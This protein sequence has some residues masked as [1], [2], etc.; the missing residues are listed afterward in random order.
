[1][2]N[3]SQLS[4]A[5]Q[6]RA[7]CFK[8]GN[9]RCVVGRMV[10]LKNLRSCRGRSALDHQHILDADWDS[11]ERRQRVALGRHSVDARSLLERA[12]FGK[13]QVDIEPRILGFN[14]FVVAGGKVGG[15]YAS[16]GNVCLQSCQG[17]RLLYKCLHAF[18]LAGQSQSLKMFDEFLPAHFC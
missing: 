12:F 9:R 8:L 1:M 13:A 6:H 15:L 10:A 11:S 4:L 18:C 5:Q 2:A 17:L 7:R 16:G 14:P 3:S